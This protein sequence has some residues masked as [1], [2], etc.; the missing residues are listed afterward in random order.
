MDEQIAEITELMTEQGYA[1]DETATVLNNTK[2]SPTLLVFRFQNQRR[3]FV[4]VG[5]ITDYFRG[6]SATAH[7]YHSLGTNFCIVAF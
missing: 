6:S 1:L 7:L 5:A 3:T 2:D 4:D